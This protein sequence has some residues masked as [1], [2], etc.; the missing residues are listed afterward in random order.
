MT[1]SEMFTCYTRRTIVGITSQMFAQ[2]NG[3]NALLYF[4]PENLTRAGFDVADACAFIYISC[5]FQDLTVASVLHRL[6]YSGISAVI[7][8]SGTVPNMLLVDSW[9]RKPL[10]LLGSVIMALCLSTV[11]GLQYWEV[12]L[13]PS[14][15][16]PAANGIFAGQAIVC[17]IWLAVFYVCLIHRGMLV[18]LC[19]WSVMGACPLASPG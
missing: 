14:A 12:S 7:Y 18:S 16:R 4:L 13:L 17:N 1:W 6:L 5:Y 9:G 2:L 3:I 8:V 15:R 10:L 19:F 11:G